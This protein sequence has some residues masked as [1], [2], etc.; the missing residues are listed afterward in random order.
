MR[1]LEVVGDIIVF[2]SRS[3]EQVVVSA[4]FSLVRRRRLSIV[5]FFERI[6]LW[7]SL[8][9]GIRGHL[10]VVCW[11]ALVVTLMVDEPK[12][13]WIGGE[14]RFRRMSPRGYDKLS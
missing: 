11:L 2:A 12:R 4:A 6:A 9:F 7:R 1:Y 13:E 10:K 3:T 5:G 8:V 14:V